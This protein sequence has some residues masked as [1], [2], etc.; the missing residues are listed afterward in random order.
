MSCPHIGPYS[1]DVTAGMACVVKCVRA[2]LRM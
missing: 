2:G 1:V